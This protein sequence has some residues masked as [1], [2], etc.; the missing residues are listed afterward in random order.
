MGTAAMNGMI[1]RL[2]EISEMFEDADAHHNVTITVRGS[3]ERSELFR[4]LYQSE[5]VT[6]Q[7]P[8]F[9]ITTV[10]IDEDMGGK[11]KSL[12]SGYYSQKAK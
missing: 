8:G 9:T 4:R 10:F 5:P 1:K 12:T 2:C 3:S 7:H 11:T 6:E